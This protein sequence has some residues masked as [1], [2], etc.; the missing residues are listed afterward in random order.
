MNQPF[1]ESYFVRLLDDRC[2]VLDLL[3]TKSLA[4]GLFKFP[5]ILQAL[6]KETTS[7]IN[8][9]TW[10]LF[11]G[12]VSTWT[13]FSFVAS[14]EITSFKQDLKPFLS[15]PFTFHTLVLGINHRIL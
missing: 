6:N 1:F 14:K 8:G 11:K 5:P 13:V 3:G 15:K 9:V 7:S 10:K 2:A 4:Q 12:T